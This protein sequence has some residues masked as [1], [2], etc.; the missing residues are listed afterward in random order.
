MTQ[1]GCLFLE[2]LKALV[3]QMVFSWLIIVNGYQMQSLW[4]IFVI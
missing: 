3:L 4:Y 1:M 2:T